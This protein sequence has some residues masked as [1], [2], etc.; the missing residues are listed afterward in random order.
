MAAAC[1]ERQRGGM[2]K[3]KNGSPIYDCILAFIISTQDSRYWLS[4]LSVVLTALKFSKNRI[5]SSSLLTKSRANRQRNA[6][7]LPN[8]LCMYCLF[9][10][11]H[12]NKLA[13]KLTALIKICFDSPPPAACL[14]NVQI[15][16]ALDYIMHWHGTGSEGRILLV[17]SPSTL[18][19]LNS[20]ILSKLLENKVNLRKGARLKKLRL[21]RKD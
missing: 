13:V 5:C 7:H 9:S 3:F 15:K 14:R 2:K 11:N 4:G 17:L 20:P 6:G 10:Q 8:V 18:E 16:H 12:N 1:W 19:A 21:Q